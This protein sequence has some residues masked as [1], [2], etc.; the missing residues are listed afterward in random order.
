[1]IMYR[2]LCS[3]VYKGDSKKEE[4]TTSEILDYASSDSIVSTNTFTLQ[5][6][7]RNRSLN[8]CTIS[9]LSTPLP[10]RVRALK[11]R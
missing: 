6:P 5:S 9:G 7:F 4:T 2:Y 1:M 3:K 11:Y 10:N 8:T